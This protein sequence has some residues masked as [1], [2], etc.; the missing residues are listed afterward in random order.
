MSFTK[1][2][3]DAVNRPTL[4]G[5]NLL[6]PGDR[7]TKWHVGYLGV[8]LFWALL[9]GRS[10]VWQ[11]KQLLDVVMSRYEQIRGKGGLPYSIDE[12]IKG[13]KKHVNES[14]AVVEVFATAAPHLRLSRDTILTYVRKFRNQFWLEVTQNQ[15]RP[16]KKEGWKTITIMV[17][18]ALVYLEE[19]GEPLK[20]SAPFPRRLRRWMRK[21][22]KDSA[23]AIVDRL[24]EQR[25]TE[26]KEA[27]LCAYAAMFNTLD[28]AKLAPFLADDFHFASQWVY[29]EI[30][31]RSEYMRYIRAKLRA[32][33]KSGKQVWAE[34]GRVNA[35]W[36]GP[37]VILAEG[38]RENLQSVILAEVNEGKLSRLD[39]C[40]VPSPYEAERT[41]F[42][43]V[44]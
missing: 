30:E 14:V 31:S 37:C 7:P 16:A 29:T 41:G 35:P 28:A 19:L 2:S 12:Y 6:S 43:P 25:E 24:K 36:P 3:A 15:L 18:W 22:K 11:D 20:P 4:F 21:L 8:E 33:E 38:R 34:T 23:S 13:K 27:A 40:F 1:H 39:E 17:G 44:R 10:A 9:V 26:I 32:I 42:Y 5:L